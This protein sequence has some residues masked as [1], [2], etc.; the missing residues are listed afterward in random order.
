MKLELVLLVSLVVMNTL[1]GGCVRTAAT[2]QPG[3]IPVAVTTTQDIVDPDYTVGMLR[4]TPIQ[5]GTAIPVSYAIT[6]SGDGINCRIIFDQLSA[7]GS[8]IVSWTLK[9]ISN[10]DG[11]FSV[12][13]NITTSKIMPINPA[14][15]DIDIKLKRNNVYILGDTV[16]YVQ[17]TKLVPVLN[18]QFGNEY[19]GEIISYEFDWQNNTGPDQG[20]TAGKITL[21]ITFNLVESQS[22]H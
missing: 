10:V 18:S 16:S 7:N 17:L 19:S 15:D 12:K 6:E 13:A 8:G 2:W 3:E 22:N 14:L 11:E 1:T 9:N 20:N 5:N 21:S 4:L